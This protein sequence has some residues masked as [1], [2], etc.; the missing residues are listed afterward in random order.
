M[1]LVPKATKTPQ[2]L[3]PSSAQRS[4][5]GASLLDI[6]LAACLLSV[7]LVP[8]FY[9]FKL[10]RPTFAKSPMEFSAT[11][12]ANH[13]MESIVADKLADPDSLPT[14]TGEE[15]IVVT[16]EGFHA[17]SEYFRHILDQT[18]GLEEKNHQVLYWSF[19]PFRCKVDT[20]YLEDYLYKVI[21][22]ISFVE[23]GQDRKIFVE[24]LL[25]HSPP[26]SLP[27]DSP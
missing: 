17:V 26:Q 6:L 22:Y 19:K 24:R 10:S 21:V 23:E 18:Q 13:V 15:P 8:L 7:S 12:L 2:V 25:E 20:Y 9:L 3:I 14:M 1:Y 27:E 16:N 11:L 5:S 4:D